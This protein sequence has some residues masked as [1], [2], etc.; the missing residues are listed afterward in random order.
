MTDI[1]IEILRAIV[2]GGIIISLLRVRHA[3][4]ISKIRGWRT[5]V[6]GFFFILFGTLIDITDNFEELG[7]FVIIGDTPVQ[8]FLEKIV[9]YLFGFLLLAIG[10]KQWLPKLIEHGELSRKKHKV[11]VQEERLKVLRATMVTVQNIVNNFLTGIQLFQMEAEEK[12]ALDPES[13]A[14]MDSIIKDTA[15][16]LNQI[17]EL[18]SVSLKKMAVGIGLDYEKSSPQEST[19]PMPLTDEGELA[20]AM[21]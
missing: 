15:T 11:E 13:L 10:I 5:L 14:L 18:D 20:G 3:K 16:K 7:R 8:A 9:G 19:K 1:I 6:A 21:R 17:A 2:V 12:N 4:E